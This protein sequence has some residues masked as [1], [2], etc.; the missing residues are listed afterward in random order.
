MKAL[1]L[2]DAED[3]ELDES[4]LYQP[5]LPCSDSLEGQDEKQKDR[6]KG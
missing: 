2:P 6:E 4:L 5:A 1:N 3:L